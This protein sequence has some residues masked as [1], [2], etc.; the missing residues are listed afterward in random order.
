MRKLPADVGSAAPLRAAAVERRVRSADRRTARNRTAIE[1]LAR[2][3]RRVEDSEV[4]EGHHGTTAVARRD[5]TVEFAAIEEER[6]DGERETVLAEYLAAKILAV[7][8]GGRQSYGMRVGEEEKN[9]KEVGHQRKLFTRKT[10]MQGVAQSLF[11]PLGVRSCAQCESRR[12]TNTDG[13]YT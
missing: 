10:I 11:I 4:G 5:E 9:G 6:V 13:R 7:G 3:E 2:D 1:T 12:G 8:E